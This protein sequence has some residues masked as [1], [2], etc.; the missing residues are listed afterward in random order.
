MLDANLAQ[1]TYVSA[2]TFE[3]VEQWARRSSLWSR[4]GRGWQLRFHQGTPIPPPD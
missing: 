3:G 2:V 4:I 1:V